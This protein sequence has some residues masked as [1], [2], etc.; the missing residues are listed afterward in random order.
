M[1]IVIAVMLAFGLATPM[2]ARDVTPTKIDLDQWEVK[3]KASVEVSKAKLELAEANWIETKQAYE[4]RIKSLEAEEKLKLVFARQRIKKN[5][6]YV[7]EAKEKELS[8]AEVDGWKASLEVSEA[9]L[10]LLKT[11]YALKK[12]EQKYA[13]ARAKSKHKSIIAGAKQVLERD[14]KQLE[15]C[16]EKIA[17]GDKEE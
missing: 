6:K 5:E 4:A 15:E 9:Y 14:K 2:F 1:K 11:Q 16:R 3:L 7:A 8:Q 13:F 10:K 12:A 17:D